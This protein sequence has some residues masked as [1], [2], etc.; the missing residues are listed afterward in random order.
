M[1]TD[2]ESDS[3]TEDPT[4]KVISPANESSTEVPECTL[5]KRYQ[6]ARYPQVERLYLDFCCSSYKEI[7]SNG[8]KTGMYELKL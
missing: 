2:R 6:R 7:G 1:K 3:M 4:N 5:E 8:P